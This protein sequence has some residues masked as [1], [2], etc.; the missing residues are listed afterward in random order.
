MSVFDPN[1]SGLVN[2]QT[3]T[4]FMLM[5]NRHTHTADQVIS[6]FKV[7]EGD[8]NFITAEEMWRVLPPHTHQAVYCITH[9]VPY[10]GPKAAPGTVD[11]KSFSTALYRD[12]NL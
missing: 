6:P 1:H 10:Q 12:S 9:M 5:E 2:F 11:Y 7:L 8:K 4:D 3:F